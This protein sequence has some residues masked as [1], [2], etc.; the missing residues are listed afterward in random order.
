MIQSYLRDLEGEL[1]VPH[2]L[3]ARILDEARD[4]LLELVDS[5]M[6]EAEAVRSF[7]AADVLAR[8]FHEQLAGASAH[9]A[10]AFSALMLLAL[11]LLAIVAPA[12][13]SAAAIAFFA[14]QVALV[15]GGLAVVRSLRYRAEGSVPPTALRD[16]YRANA[17]TL[18]CVSVIVVSSAIILVPSGGAAVIAATAGLGVAALLAA[19][20]LGR[21]LARARAVASSE[22]E[23]DAYDDLLALAPVPLRQLAGPLADWIRRHP[24]TF[25]ALFAAACGLVTGGGHIVT[26]GGFSGDPL[27][28]AAAVLLLGGIEA[29]AVALGFAALGGMLGIRRSRA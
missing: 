9:R 2:R 22:P 19:V 5:G 17:V 28:A 10:S 18:S 25:C 16:I 8:D 4:H 6:S 15:A 13:S 29:A 26:D 7:G 27:R 23:G 1:Q 20:A 24:W 11:A 12:S 14:G 3:R 21:S